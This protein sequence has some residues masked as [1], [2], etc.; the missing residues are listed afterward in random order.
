MNP[1]MAEWIEKASGNVI[2]VQDNIRR[3]IVVVNPVYE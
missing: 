2:A 3:Q 1:R